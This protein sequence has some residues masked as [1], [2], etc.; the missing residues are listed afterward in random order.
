M[1]LAKTQVDNQPNLQEKPHQQ[2][3]DRVFAPKSGKHD[4][5]WDERSC[6]SSIVLEVVRSKAHLSTR[7]E[8]NAQ[9]LP[10]SGQD[11]GLKYI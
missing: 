2:E 6:H 9:I 5:A 10:R 7:T 8:A 1:P 4:E 11:S 3:A